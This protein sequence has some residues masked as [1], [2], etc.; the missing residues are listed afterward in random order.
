MARNPA[1]KLWIGKTGVVPAPTAMSD[2][3]ME[4]IDELLTT[5]LDGRDRRQLENDT[6]SRW[7]AV[8]RREW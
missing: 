3:H 7:M 1:Q 6:S 2:E 4:D 8:R 5:R